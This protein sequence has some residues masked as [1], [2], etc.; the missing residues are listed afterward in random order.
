MALT[1]IPSTLIKNLLETLNNQNDPDRV[2][3]AKL[4]E[5]VEDIEY[6]LYKQTN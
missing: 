5:Q 3:L 2:R 4:L 1:P 6:W